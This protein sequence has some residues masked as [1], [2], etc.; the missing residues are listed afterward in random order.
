[1]ADI[2][3]CQVATRMLHITLWV[4]QQFPKLSQSE[5][6]LNISWF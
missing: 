2:E 4:T 5:D 6:N 3:N 1:M